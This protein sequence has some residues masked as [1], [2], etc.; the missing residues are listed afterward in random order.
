M[1]VGAGAWGRAKEKLVEC[2][3]VKEPGGL[4]VRWDIHV[5]TEITHGDARVWDKEEDWARIKFCEWV[6]GLGDP[7][8]VDQPPWPVLNPKLSSIEQMSSSTMG[9]VNE[10]DR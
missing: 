9:C 10:T 6:K 8:V 2:V 5:D 1:A 3:C 4:D 7:I